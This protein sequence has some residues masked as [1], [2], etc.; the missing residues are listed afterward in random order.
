MVETALPVRAG[1]WVGR[2]PAQDLVEAVVSALTVPEAIGARIAALVRELG[3]SDWEK[4]EAAQ[5][6]LAEM[7][8]AALTALEEA[9][10]QAEDPEVR[11]RARKLMEG[12]GR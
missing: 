3:D 4:R 1:T 7:G 9:S 6:Q 5:R 11:K 2:V 12:A 10:E 8:E